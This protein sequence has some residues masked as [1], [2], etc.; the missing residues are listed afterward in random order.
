M[1]FNDAGPCFCSAA[2]SQYKNMQAL[3][4]GDPSC[5]GSPVFLGKDYIT[6]TNK[7]EQTNGVKGAQLKAVTHYT[8]QGNPALLTLRLVHA[9]FAKTNPLLRFKAQ[10]TLFPS[11]SCQAQASLVEK[12]NLYFC[13]RF[14]TS[15]L[16]S[17]ATPKLLLLENRLS[18]M[19]G[20]ALAMPRQQ[21]CLQ[22]WVGE[23]QPQQGQH[24]SS[25]EIGAY[26]SI[27]SQEKTQSSLISVPQRGTKPQN[28]L[29]HA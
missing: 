11:M 2:G 15:L 23:H 3:A 20:P 14:D 21:S 16:H 26:Y 27:P 29:I 8:I 24:N 19:P 4:W 6:R 13:I 7:P 28:L 22:N 5:S 12:K 9:N 25:Q 18:G 10:N 1:K 17:K